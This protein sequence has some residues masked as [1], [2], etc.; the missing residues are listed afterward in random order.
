MSRHCPGGGGGGGGGAGGAPPNPPPTT[1]PPLH[2]HPTPQDAA[3][4]APV[5]TS[6]IWALPE[7]VGD[8]GALVDPYNTDAICETLAELL[9]NQS[10]RDEL[11]R[12]GLERARRFTWPQ[13]AEQTV[14]VYKEIAN[15][16]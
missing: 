13:V 2:D 7:G 10:K 1:R 11:A 12:R 3:T 6:N 16:V 9:E 15:K 8:G 4:L 5:L 14:R